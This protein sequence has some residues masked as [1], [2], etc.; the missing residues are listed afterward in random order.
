LA[1]S[2]TDKIWDGVVG[3]YDKRA[4]AALVLMVATTNVF[5]R[6]NVTTWQLAGAWG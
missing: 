1:G 4:L 2:G 6:F 3:H 5:N